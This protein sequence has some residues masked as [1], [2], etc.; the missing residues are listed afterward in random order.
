M[1]KLKFFGIIL[2]VVWFHPILAQNYKFGKVSKEELL[3]T[4]F[5]EDSEANAAILFEKRKVKIT[6]QVNE[7]FRVVTEVFK[8]IKLYNKD[9]F[10]HATEQVYLYKNGSSKEKI[11]SLRA[12]TYSLVNN[13]IVQTKL[14]KDG[15]FEE[16][17]SDYYD[18]TKFTM[19]SLSV[20][21]VVEYQYKT[22]SPFLASI[23][24]IALQYDIPLKKQEVEFHSPEFYSY[25]KFTSGYLPINLS[26]S[27]VNDK[28][29]FTTKQRAG[30]T[31]FNVVKT[32]F[33]QNTVDFI[34]NIDKINATNVPAFKP[35]PYSGNFQNY[36][37]SISYE[38]SYVKFPN[39]PIDYRSTTW[40]NVVK[41]IF[42]HPNFGDELRKDSY[43]KKEI[44]AL[45]E[46]IS[47]PEMKTLAIYSFVKKY[48]TWNGQRS[49]IVKNGVKKA[50][51]EKTGNSA[52][53]NL[54]LT[55]MLNYA[56]LDA[57]PVV[58][59][60]SDKIISFFPTINGFNYV[61][62][63]VRLPEGRIVFLD[64]TD[65]FGLPNLLPD[66]VLRGFGRVIDK[67]GKSG[68]VTFRSDKPSVRNINL[69]CEINSEGTIKGKM[70][71]RRMQYLA[72][73]F[74]V[75]HGSKNE[76]ALLKRFENNYG[77]TET[78]GYKISGVHDLNKGVTEQFTFVLENQAEVIDNEVFFSPLLFLK[79]KENIFKS[80]ERKYPVDFGYG[81][82]NSFILNIKIPEGYQ[83]T[84]LPKSGRYQ[85]PQN[86]GSF[87]IQIAESNGTLQVVVHETIAKSL[88]TSDY[89]PALKEFYDQIIRKENEQVVLKKVS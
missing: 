6:Y 4:S 41:K 88:I 79:D 83:V 2:F 78:Q 49:V 76:E 42:Q 25:K 71:V 62:A 85:L 87:S 13:T 61:V 59:G 45:I 74:R 51:L 29:N 80:E 63:R 70:G 10:K 48:M 52:E 11:S 65:K 77:I 3:E 60:T 46:G 23:D 32:N 18:I 81:F 14:K 31:G 30:G 66:R 73:T 56:K 24:R 37:A 84:E 50:F 40:E 57:N 16:E 89:Y 86:V 19:P 9:G 17:F 39:E 8:R 12:C 27:K 72:H 82:T 20:G 34:T 28:I 69:Q 22:I 43:Y 35:E 38:L 67:S 15:I 47:D 54:M 55:S 7:G 53:I 26:S 5:Q 1:R 21:T 36:K 44:D 64:A 33:S 75:R 58:V 68:M